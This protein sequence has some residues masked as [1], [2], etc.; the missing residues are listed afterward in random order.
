MI[1]RR[2]YS[3]TNFQLPVV[4]AANRT[5]A[6]GVGAKGADPSAADYL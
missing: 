4:S 2:A 1:M 3:Q 5:L 6:L